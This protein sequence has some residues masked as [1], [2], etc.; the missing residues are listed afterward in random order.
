TGLAGVGVPGFNWLPRRDFQYSF[1]PEALTVDRSGNLYVAD[2]LQRRVVRIGADGV[3]RAVVGIVPSSKIGIRF[4][5]D[6]GPADQAEISFPYGLAVDGEG[7][8]FLSDTANHRVRKVGADGIIHTVAGT[9][10][11]GYSGDHGP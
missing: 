9:G 6:E 3:I 8:L 1:S 2:D 10:A 4:S 11:P 5:G 7:N